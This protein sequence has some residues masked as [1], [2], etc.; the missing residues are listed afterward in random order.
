MI[1]VVGA[2][3]FLLRGIYYSFSVFRC[4]S[5]NLTDCFTVVRLVSVSVSTDEAEPHATH[6]G[7]PAGI[8]PA[9]NPVASLGVRVKGAREKLENYRWQ[10]YYEEIPMQLDVAHLDRLKNDMNVQN[11]LFR[12]IVQYY[13]QHTHYPKVDDDS[14]AKD[15]NVRTEMQIT[16]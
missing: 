9:V 14:L 5:A 7:V 3:S 15:E 1:I 12:A 10:N 13:N 11:G 16:M 2:L 4:Y 8:K 6:V